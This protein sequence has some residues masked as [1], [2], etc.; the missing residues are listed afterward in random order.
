MPIQVIEKRCPQNHRC[1]A[2]KVCPV[3]AIEQQGNSAPTIKK[4]LCI[5]CGKCIR[6]CPM[7][8]LVLVKEAKRD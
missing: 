8:A 2:I 5:D 3:N 4:D 6:F 7:G 1:P